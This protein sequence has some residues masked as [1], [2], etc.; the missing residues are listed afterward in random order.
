MRVRENI[1]LIAVVIL[2]LGAAYSRNAV[3]LD[4]ISVWEDVVMR[5]PRNPRANLNLG[6]VY[7]KKGRFDEAVVC[8]RAALLLDPDYAEAN[9]G[10]GLAY[11]YRG[12][13]DEAAFHYETALR[14][15]ARYAGAH[16]NFG[17]LHLNRGKKYYDKAKAE[18]EE[19]LRIKPDDAGARSLYQYIEKI[20][21][22]E[23]ARPSYREADHGVTLRQLRRRSRPAAA[24]CVTCSLK[25]ARI[26]CRLS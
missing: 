3:W 15:N 26:S 23:S 25:T 19:V 8:Y 22:R 5:Y 14:L 18:F 10:L 1:P 21:P 20:E 7:N 24:P 13:L 12:S 2:L 16:Y 9:N 11:T 6:S 17:M 4:D